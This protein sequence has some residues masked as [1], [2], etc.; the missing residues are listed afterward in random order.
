[1]SETIATLSGDPDGDMGGRIERD[2][3]GFVAV[4]EDDEEIGT[5]TE[6]DLEAL[7]ETGHVVDETGEGQAPELDGT[8]G[9]SQIGGLMGMLLQQ[10]DHYALTIHDSEDEEDGAMALV[11]LDDLKALDGIAA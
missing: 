5:L 1:M 8:A 10:Q 11:T 3:D 4:S 9:L 6:S 2:G 7:A